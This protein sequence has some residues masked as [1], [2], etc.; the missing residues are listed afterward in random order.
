M[1]LT[2]QRHCSSDKLDVTLAVSSIDVINVE[3]KIKKITLKKRGEN[4]RKTF[5]NVG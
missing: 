2:H 4:K 5:V 3:M 1:N